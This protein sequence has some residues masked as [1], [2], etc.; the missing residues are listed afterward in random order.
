[1][2]GYIIDSTLGA[3]HSHRLDAVVA[4]GEAKSCANPSSSSSSKMPEA[5][6]PTREEDVEEETPLSGGSCSIQQKYKDNR[7][8]QHPSSYCWHAG[9]D[10]DLIVEK[11]LWRRQCC[12]MD[13][14]NHNHV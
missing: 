6:I 14:H 11:R 8:S 12:I 1:M 10:D 9:D 2:P 5:L 3:D 7:Q 4:H 13:G